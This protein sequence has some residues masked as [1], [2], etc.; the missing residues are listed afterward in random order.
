MPAPTHDAIIVAG[1]AGTRLGSAVAKAFV[2]LNGKPMVQYSL[3][4]FD[5]HP[6]IDALVLVVP[7]AMI[8][9]AEKIVGSKRF[10]KPI[11]LVAGGKERWLSV[12][13][14]VMA[15]KAQWVLIHDAARPFVTQAVIDAVLEQSRTYSAVI[16]ATKEVDTVRRFSGDRA[17]ET[18]DRDTLIRVGTPQLFDR[19]ALVN[20][21]NAAQT[22][23]TPPTDEAMLM[24]HLGVPVGIAWGDP[25]NFKITTKSDLLLAEALCRRG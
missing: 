5:A 2:N 23:K 22:M 25:L 10:K 24:E 20:A 3:E 6:A 9:L 13:N 8:G 15:S 19:M 1:G 12:K 17:M 16:T 7:A 11:R 21:F 4:R 14:G 18:I